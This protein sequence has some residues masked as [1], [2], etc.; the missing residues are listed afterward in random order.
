MDN[1]V[2]ITLDDILK[3]PDDVEL[4]PNINISVADIIN[5]PDD[6]ITEKIFQALKENLP[7]PQESSVINESNKT[8]KHEQM[9]T[10]NENS[11]AISQSS[12]ISKSKNIFLTGVG[13]ETHSQL[14]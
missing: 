7:Q 13:S 3:E 9:P 11:N 14:F 8:Q 12:L 2:N 1:K 5:E 4:D 10:K 6:D